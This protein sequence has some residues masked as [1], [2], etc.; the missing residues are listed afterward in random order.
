MWLSCSRFLCFASKHTHC[1]SL[2]VTVSDR[3]QRRRRQQQ[4][5]GVRNVTHAL[6]LLLSVQV[7]PPPSFPSWQ[8]DNRFLPVFLSIEL[9]DRQSYWK[10]CVPWSVLTDWLSAHVQRAVMFTPVNSPGAQEVEFS[11][12]KWGVTLSRWVSVATV[13]V[14]T[15]R[16]NKQ[17][18]QHGL[19]LLH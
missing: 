4:R 18:P 14:L 7:L 1:F 13:D 2:G 17:K 5:L 9:P 8:I 10:K 15:W 12:T 3:V 11:E 16:T 6:L 19:N